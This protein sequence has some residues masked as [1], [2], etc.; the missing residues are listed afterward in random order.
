MA[1][2]LPDINIDSLVSKLISLGDM[3]KTIR[4]HLSYRQ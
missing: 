1:K 4:E 3:E 2:V